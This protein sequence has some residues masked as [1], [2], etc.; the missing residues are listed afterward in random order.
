MPGT[1]V[2]GEAWLSEVVEF[3]VEFCP[4][5][6]RDSDLVRVGLVNE[7]IGPAIPVDVMLPGALLAVSVGAPAS[8]SEE[9]SAGRLDG[10]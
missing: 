3:V 1:T 4:M 9:S 7:D 5:L 10:R 2:S 8:T 6:I